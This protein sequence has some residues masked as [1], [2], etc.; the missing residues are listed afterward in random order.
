M[1]LGRLRPETLDRENVLTFRLLICNLVPRA[2]GDPSR[3]HT[4]I[5]RLRYPVIT[6]IQLAFP[7]AATHLP[8]G[9]DEDGAQ[10]PGQRQQ[11][12]QTSS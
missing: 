7:C 6:C 11:E 3:T 10:A 5:G 4:R 1:P 2:F 12:L 9:G 8:S